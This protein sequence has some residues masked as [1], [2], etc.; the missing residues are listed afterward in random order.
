LARFQSDEKDRNMP[1]DEGEV[2]RRL[3]ELD[4]AGGLKREEIKQRYQSLP[5]EIFIRL[6]SSKRYYRPAEVLANTGEASHSRAEG[7]FLGP[8]PGL[9]TDGAEEDGGPPAWGDSPTGQ[10]G[11]TIGR[12]DAPGNGDMGG[13]R[14]ETEAGRGLPPDERQREPADRGTGLTRSRKA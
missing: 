7:E 8:H 4:W 14:I 9:P 13:N 10:M 12:G 1:F 11:T 3:E 6:P 5:D 2:T